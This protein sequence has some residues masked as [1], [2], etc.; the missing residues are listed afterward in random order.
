MT[1]ESFRT[2]PILASGKRAIAARLCHIDI[3]VRGTSPKELASW[4]WDFDAR[5][6][7]AGEASSSA[8]AVAG[9]V[10]LKGTL[11]KTEAFLTAHPFGTVPAAF[12]PDGSIGIFESNSI[13]RA[14]ARIG[15]TG[16]HSMATDR[17]KPRAS[18]AFSTSAWCLRA[19]RK[20]IC[21]R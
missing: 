17:M 16:F 9:K 12:S 11:H 1:C 5:P 20:C 2:C 15:E 19:I 21:S 13:M 6:L 7:T 18:T 8:N 14:V 4:L 3:E 10:G